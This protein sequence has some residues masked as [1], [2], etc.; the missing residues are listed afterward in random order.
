M[1]TGR[2]ASSTPVPTTE[3]G[4]PPAAD[5]ASSTVTEEEWKAMSTVLTNVYAHRTEE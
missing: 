1:A 4:D 3:T 2:A 5:G